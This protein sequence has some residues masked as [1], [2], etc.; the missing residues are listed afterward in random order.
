MNSATLLAS[1][2]AYPALYASLPLLP[3]SLS[4]PPRMLLPLYAG[5]GGVAVAVVLL[6]DM[7][8]PIHSLLALMDD[9]MSFA[10]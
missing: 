10:V 9:F 4:L 3:L 8:Y 5:C 6:I 1:S 2:L 7:T